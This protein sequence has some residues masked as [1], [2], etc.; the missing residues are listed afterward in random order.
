MSLFAGKQQSI[1]VAQGTLVV[2]TGAGTA[3]PRFL[4]GGVYY[5][6]FTVNGSINYDEGINLPVTEVGFDMYYNNNPAQSVVVNCP[7]N[8]NFS[9]SIALPE[10]TEVEFEAYA[11]A[12]APEGKFKGGRG[13]IAF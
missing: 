11:K 1:T 5:K 4:I 8:I 3:S 13:S 12:G 10:D 6:T 9:Y 2:T 7:N